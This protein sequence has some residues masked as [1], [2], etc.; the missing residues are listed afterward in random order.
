MSYRDLRN[1]TEMMRGLGYRRLISLENFRSPNFPL[2]AE[3][4]SWLVKRYDPNA[5]IQTS[6]ET[7]PERVMF[8]ISVAEFMA[9]KAHIKLNTKKLY[10]AD[11]YA[12]KE[13]LKVTTVLYNAMKTN[14]SSITESPEEEVAPVSFD[15]SSKIND[16][17]EARRLASEITTKGALLYDLLGKEV[18]LREERSA[19]IAKPLEINEV[20]V[21]LQASIKAVENE[22][23]KTMH[24]LDNVASDEANL[25]AK[26]EKKRNELDR[27]QKRL[28]TLQSVRPA[29]M[30]EYEKFEED[31]Q[32]LYEAY[33][34]KFR[35][36]TYLENQLEEYNRAEQDRS[37]ETDAALKQM[38]ERLKSEER[39]SILMADPADFARESESSEEEEEEE[40][41]GDDDMGETD[42][43]TRQTKSGAR[44]GRPD[45]ATGE[46][47]QRVIGSMLDGMGEDSGSE[48]SG[49]SDID[50]DDDDDDGDLES[51]TEMEMPTAN[52][53]LKAQQNK[54]D[55][56]DSD[57]DF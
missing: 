9:R 49:D 41:E 36:L 24:M 15:I 17:K 11:G 2:V 53:R 16:L 8:I 21:G 50:L 30:D 14:V 51:G 26:I 39:K 43:M 29:Y 35:N 20:E 55:L 4:L 47:K 1:F 28:L 31:L 48:G 18:E 44:R 7:E 3:V 34:T 32:K 25:E 45:A 12:V 10:Q 6:T 13:L 33:I 27:N 40:E 22:I 19:V 37:E 42:L 23:K 38:A 5:D 54:M 57:N 56:D 46:R 52:P